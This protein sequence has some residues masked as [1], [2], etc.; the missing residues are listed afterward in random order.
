MFLSSLLSGRRATRRTRHSGSLSRDSLSPRL[1]RCEPL[2]QRQL[3]SAIHTFSNNTPMAIKDRGT[4]TSA[5]SVPAG[6]LVST[7][8]LDI[9][10]TR[11]QDLSV[12]LIG[13]DRTR[14]LL[15]A[16]VGGTGHNFTGT[17]LD[18]RSDLKI[19]QGSAPFTGTYHPRGFL[20]TFRGKKTDGTWKLEVT[21]DTRGE[22]GRLNSWS[23]AMV[24]A[25]AVSTSFLDTDPT[26]L[27]RAIALT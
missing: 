3:L 26:I 4:I 12:S 24:E 1:L 7:V 20:D 8:T 10:H 25:S 27:G 16:D 9:T 22:T 2:E 13:P 14:V 19:T 6:Y 11:D 5:I 15:F 21:D 23:L 17:K 18:D